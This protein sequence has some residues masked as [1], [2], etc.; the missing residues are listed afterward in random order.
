MQLWEHQ[1][2]AI[3]LC[4]AR[5]EAPHAR[6]LVQ[7]PPGTGKT[8]VAARVAIEWVKR[9][10]FRRI[11]IAV[12]TAPIMRQYYAR[13]VALTNITVAIEKAAVEILHFKPRIVLASQA[14]LWNR[15]E[16][17]SED[18]LFITD[19]CQHANYD[20]PENLR[21][22]ERFQ[23]VVGLSASPW[24]S[25]CDELFRQSEGYFLSL[26]QAQELRLVA[27]HEIKL[28]TPEQGPWGLVFCETNREC[29]Q[30]SATR[31]RSSWIG[32]QV[33]EPLINQRIAAWRAGQLDVLYVNRMLL[34][35][36]DEKRCANVWLDKDTESQ[37]MIVQMAGRALRYIN[38]KTATIYCRTEALIERVRLAMERLNS[39][40]H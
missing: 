29:A 3:A 8:E 10:P 14:T 16:R 39:R 21:L 18:T 2:E 20:A 26:L 38:G 15:I 13:L 9:G 11:L 27:P 12:P 31:P 24:S 32:V 7:L 5:L 4:L 28:W 40:S 33:A 37:I 17:Y 25:G 22:V 23:R 6:V 35:G 1:Q 30:R 36:F 19:E 34:E